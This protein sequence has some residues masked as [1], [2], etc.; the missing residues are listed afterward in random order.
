MTS[1]NMIACPWIVMLYKAHVRQI[2]H[3]GFS[4]LCWCCDLI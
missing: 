2:S 3:I 4:W 1:C